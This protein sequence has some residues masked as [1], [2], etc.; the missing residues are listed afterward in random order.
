MK[1][2]YLDSSIPSAYYGKTQPDRLKI[3]QKWWEEN[4]HCYKVFTSELAQKEIEALKQKERR[5][6]ILC[7]IS[8]FPKLKVTNTIRKIAREYVE[9]G[10]IPASA[11]NDA[12]HL[13]IA[14]IYR[15]QIFL[16]WNFA[17]IVNRQVERKLRAFNLVSGFPYIH[18]TT[19]AKLI[20]GKAI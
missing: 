19:P 14:S 4:I 11:F 15:I 6:L 17:H 18:I 5:E 12:L 13:A 1:S 7:L 10:I 9:E 16:T 8:N 3:T 20:E 2:L